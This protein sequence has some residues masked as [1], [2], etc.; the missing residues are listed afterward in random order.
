MWAVAQDCQLNPAPSE[1]VCF[2]RARRPDIN[3]LSAHRAAGIGYQIFA[4]V[5]AGF[6]SDS[7]AQGQDRWICGNHSLGWPAATGG[8]PIQTVGGG[9]E[10]ECGHDWSLDDRSTG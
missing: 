5:A 10:Y 9:Q 6:D 4:A 7:A 8:T 3:L 2:A 1:V